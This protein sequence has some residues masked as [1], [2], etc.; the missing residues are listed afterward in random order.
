[1]AKIALRSLDDIAK[2]YVDVT[3]ARATYYE[4]GVR[5]PSK[6]WAT[7]TAAAAPTYKAAVQDP[8]I[9]KLFAGGVKRAGTPKWQR[10]AVN[11]GVARYGPGVA[12]AGDDYKAGFAP[13]HDELSKIDLPPKKPRG[14]LENAERVKKIMDALHKKR[15]AIMAVSTSP[16]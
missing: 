8:N 13:F 9:D 16:T 4:A 12:A 1:M 5:A 14:S 7:E 6:D 3:P 11:L 2:K 15:L 10:K